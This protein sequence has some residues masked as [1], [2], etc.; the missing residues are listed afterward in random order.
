MFKARPV[1]KGHHEVR[2]SL[3]LWHH[4]EVSQYLASP[5]CYLVLKMKM[6][7]GGQ[8]KLLGKFGITSDEKKGSI[9]SC[10]HFPSHN[11]L[12]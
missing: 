7:R 1:M 10:G 5:K 11:N 4:E 6:G 2:K 12:T 9:V 3:S 8:D